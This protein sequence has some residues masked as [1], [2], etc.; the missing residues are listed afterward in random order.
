MWVYLFGSLVRGEMDAH[1]D[2]DMLCIY[3]DSDYESI[4][5]YMQKYTVEEL[6]EIFKEGDLFAYH[7]HTESQLIYTSDGID[8]IRGIGTPELYAN[9]K[10]DLNTF[11]ELA[12][13]SLGKLKESKDSIFNKGILYM[14]LRDMAMIYTHVKMAATDF[15]K[16]VPY[17]TDIPFNV[18]IETYESLRLCRLSS[19]RGTWSDGIVS[20][21]PDECYVSVRDWILEVDE[22]RVSCA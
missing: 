14:S 10:D 11:I 17:H 6:A 19:T 16:Y 12:L 21:L 18:S 22:W 4:P 2:V 13:Y 20:N 15:S 9:W 8:I 7:L 1:S 5:A 3:E